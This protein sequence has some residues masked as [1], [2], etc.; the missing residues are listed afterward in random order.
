MTKV[1]VAPL[2]YELTNTPL[3]FSRG[4][5]YRLEK[6]KIIPPLLRLGGK[7]LLQASTVADIVSG[8]IVLPQNAGRMKS[9]PAA[10]PGRL[11]QE[12]QAQ[13]QARRATAR[14]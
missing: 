11:D 5:W 12:G 1:P 8:K 9:A 4:T 13:A 7:T 2:A 6:Q 14:R 10:G 3:P